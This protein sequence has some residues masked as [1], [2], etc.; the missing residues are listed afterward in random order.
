MRFAVCWV[1]QSTPCRRAL[2]HLRGGGLTGAGL[3]QITTV[4]TDATAKADL[5]QVVDSLVSNSAGGA[6]PTDTVPGA[7]RP[8][9]VWALYFK[10]NGASPVAATGSEASLPSGIAITGRWVA[11]LPRADCEVQSGWQ[12]W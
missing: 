5:Q 6:D 2:R 11:I 3:L 12:T 1:Y 7:A 4:G 9:A 10:V 8:A